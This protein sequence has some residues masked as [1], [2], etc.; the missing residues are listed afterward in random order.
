MSEQMLNITEKQCPCSELL[1]YLR[2]HKCM[3]CGKCVFGYDGTTQLIM[4]LEDI[5]AKRGRNTDY[6]QMKILAGLIAEQSMCE[7]GELL[8]KTVLELLEKYMD[9]FM[10]HITKKG[11]TAAV[12]K[13]FVTYHIL[14][15]KCIG[16]GDCID[17][18]MD[19]AILGK[20]RFVHVINQKDC[21]Q[22]GECLDSCSEGAIV[23]AGADKP[24]CPARPIPV[25]R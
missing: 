19:E 17:A 21:T 14:Q 25:R 7:D 5:T 23:T 3:S 4:M 10:L 18:C 13:Q 16:C 2:D 20:K 1:K 6:D 24:R 15:D 9:E 12:C 11:C 8:G 22:C